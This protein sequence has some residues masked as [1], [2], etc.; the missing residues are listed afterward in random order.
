MAGLPREQAAPVDGAECGP[1][2]DG[3]N[4]NAVVPGVQRCRPGLVQP[5]KLLL[6]RATHVHF[7]DSHRQA[8]ARMR[9]AQ[10]HP[11]AVDQCT[12]CTDGLDVGIGLASVAAVQVRWVQF[13]PI[14]Q[15][16]LAGDVGVDADDVGRTGRLA[17]AHEFILP[18]A[19]AAQP[20]PQRMPLID[21]AAQQVER[22]PAALVVEGG[23]VGHGGCRAREAEIVS[24]DEPGRRVDVADGAHRKHGRVHLV[25]QRAHEAGVVRRMRIPQAV[26]AG[27]AG[28]RQWLVDRRP[29]F[30]VWKA[31]G[32]LAGIVGEQ[33]G[34]VRIDQA[35]VARAAAVVQ[36]PDDGL[37]P[38]RVQAGDRTGGPREVQGTRQC[39]GM[40]P[41][42]GKSHALRAQRGETVDVVGPAREAGQRRLVTPTVV[43]PIDRA[44][45][46]D[47]Q[48]QRLLHCGSPAASQAGTIDAEDS[49]VVVPP[50]TFC[51]NRAAASF[52]NRV[53][54]CATTWSML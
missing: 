32:D 27:E 7:G 23:L 15:E 3:A 9:F 25:Q 26:Q 18:G 35:G 37:K 24:L 17:Q 36:Q 12:M 1:G 6:A 43:D 40:F 2:G 4:I 28:R 19:A 41:K 54:D 30:H 44:L 13:Q 42:N 39:G 22:Q 49:A 31:L 50:T 47:P 11:E 53:N 8:V 33:G 51:T 29:A 48:L 5:A 38:V 34:E 21:P 16:T 14:V 45:R 20:G 46:A 52:L 10:S